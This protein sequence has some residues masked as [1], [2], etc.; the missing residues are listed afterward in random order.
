[1]KL[2]AADWLLDNIRTDSVQ[3]GVS[4]D[5]RIDV[6]VAYAAQLTRAPADID[7][8]NTNRLR[9]VGLTDLEILALNNVVAYYNHVDRVANGLG[10]RSNV[11]A[12]DEGPPS[13]R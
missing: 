8:A 12:G 2:S 9:S 4:D 3:W 5:D 11:V 6:I 13:A 1:V 7:E 10:L